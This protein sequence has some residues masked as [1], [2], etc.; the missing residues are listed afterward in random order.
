VPT[1]GSLAR[2]LGLTLWSLTAATTCP[3][4]AAENP[5]GAKFCGSCGAALSATCPACGH[6]NAPGTSFCT[7]C[8]T[9]LAT[10]AL[11]PSFASPDTYTPDDLA[12]KIRSGRTEIEGERK[13]I[14]VMFADVAGFTSLSERL[15]P[16]E[17]HAI[18]NRC[19]DL[20]LDEVHRY[21]GTVSQFL[22]D[23]MLALFGA[24]IAHEDHA[25]RAVRA[26]LGI[27]SALTGYR[28]DMKQER[29]IDFR[30]RIGLNSGPVVVG[31][32]GADLA[33]TYTAVGD[34]VNLAQRMETLAAPGSV[35]VSEHTHRLIE[36]YFVTRDLGEQAVKGKEEP[37]RV[38]EVLRPVRWRSRVDVYADRGLAPFVGRDSDLE[39]LLGAIAAA[40]K[41]SGGVVVIRGE[42]GIGKSRLLYEA[43]GRLDTDEVTWLV[44]RCISYGAGT[45]YL[46]IID[47]V[48]DA[49][50]IDEADSEDEVA[51]KVDASA[52]ASAAPYLRHLLAVDPGDDSIPTMDP[53]LR[54]AKTFEAL[55]DLALAAAEVRPQ[56]LVVED[57]HWV[58]QASVEFLSY[59]ADYVPEHKILLVLTHRPD[60]EQPLGTRPSFVHIDLQTLSESETAAVTDAL[61]GAHGMPAELQQLVFAKAEGN[62]FFVEEVTRSLVETGVLRRVNSH[63]ELA[64]PVDEIHVPDTVQDVI[65]AR[66]DRLPEEPRRAIQTAAV[67][68]REFTVRLLERT[69]DLHGDEAGEQLRE[70]KSVE[71]IYERSLYPELAYMFKHALTHDVA[72]ESLLMAR[73]KALHRLVAAAVEELYEDRLAE[74]YETI[75]FHAEQGEAWKQAFEYLGRSGD[76]ALA[77]YAPAQ[78]AEFYERALALVEGGK[79]GDDPAQMLPLHAGR[80]E[81]YWILSR[82]GESAAAYL[83]MRSAAKALGDPVHEGVALFQAGI[84]LHWA[85]RFEEAMEC[86]ERAREI[87]LELGNDA[88]VAGSLI[89]VEGVYT[90]TGDQAAAAGVIEEA[91]RAAARS[92]VP[93]L[94]GFT[95]VWAGFSHHW[96][97]DEVR[98]LEIW[99]NA[100][101][102][103]KE[104]ELPI[105]LLWTLWNQ[106]LALIGCGRYGDALASLGEHSELTT[107]VGDKVFRCRTLNTLGW[108]YIDLCNWERAIEHN[109][110]GS[111]ESRAVGDPEIIRN[112]ELN[113]GDCYLALGELDEARKWLER[114]ETES[115]QS[116]AWGEEWMKW[117]YTQHMNASL[118][119]LWL[120][121]G[122]PERALG[123]ADACIAR[124][125]ETFSKRNIAKGRRARGKALRALGE[126]EQAQNELEGALEVA[127]QVGN[128]AQIQQTLEALE[129]PREALEIAEGIAGSLA[130]ADLRKTFLASPQVAELRNAATS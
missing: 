91:S 84:S 39:A 28:E 48:K 85:H 122:E 37:V 113:L 72:Y 53:Q 43:R 108:A 33:M 49:F 61:L 76:K 67:I 58:D 121:Y 54:K 110:Q 17:T 75:A 97:G 71:L 92:Q 124:A 11:Q 14:T 105:V 114:V 62:P 63:Y 26:A 111:E 25:Q 90:V 95:D 107:R 93:L 7:E 32:I 30:M 50:G 19:F 1:S 120:A 77:A 112:A 115:A 27:Q 46:P 81:A 55:R 86:A 96:R 9:P 2:Q 15:D 88:I 128:P 31:N 18:M 83:E 51:H 23:G 125:E 74:H 35:L 80:G 109:L 6:R 38:Y 82:F 104:H 100:V 5:D 129:R 101:R 44:G 12:A 42:A 34:T 123:Y 87:G 56:V 126:L 118:S 21:E 69:A 94:E 22:G 24:P 119:E 99:D 98:A 60:W 102:I 16:E 3:I 78:A 57:L 10:A 73:R 47:L 68:G 106:A 89:T 117:R 70:L 65:M 45:P 52:S 59:V 36:G 41:G 64:R 13:Q 40:E 20:M 103:G 79:V 66:L 116:G 4:C 127:R 8:G 130:D 29:G